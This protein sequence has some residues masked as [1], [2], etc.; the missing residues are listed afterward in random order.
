MKLIFFDHVNQSRRTSA[1]NFTLALGRREKLQT[2]RL[3][4]KDVMMLRMI[5]VS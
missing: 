2:E 3:P 4:H 1:R 5:H